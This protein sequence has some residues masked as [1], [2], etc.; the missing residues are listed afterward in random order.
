[1]Y[2]DKIGMALWEMLNG[3]YITLQAQFDAL[4]ETFLYTLDS[5]FRFVGGLITVLGALWLVLR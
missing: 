4:A 5:R 2:A 1:M 3:I